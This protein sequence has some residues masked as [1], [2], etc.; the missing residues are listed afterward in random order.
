MLPE[1]ALGN[2]QEV[3]KTWKKRKRFLFKAFIQP[4]LSHWQLLKA[5]VKNLS[6]GNSN[7]APEYFDIT[8]LPGGHKRL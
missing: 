1:L 8:V 3:Y 7:L 4:L 6:T 2:S 5:K